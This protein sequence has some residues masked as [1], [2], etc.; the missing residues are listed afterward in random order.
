MGE[1]DDFGPAGLIT[2]VMNQEEI[3]QAILYLA[4][5]PEERRRMG[6]TGYRRVMA[7]Y[8]IE[9]MLDAYRR[10]YAD[11]AEKIERNKS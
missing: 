10:I 5:H 4:H 11:F 1:A 8:R 2:H 7:R 9:H 6:E 3:A